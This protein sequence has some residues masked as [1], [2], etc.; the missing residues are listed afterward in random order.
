MGAPVF[1]EGAW[2][3]PK[4]RKRLLNDRAHAASGFLSRQHRNH[5]EGEAQPDASLASTW[6]VK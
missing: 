3:T 5:L 1:C 6:L 4:A 2:K